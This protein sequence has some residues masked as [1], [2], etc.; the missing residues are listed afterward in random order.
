MH[1]PANKECSQEKHGHNLC[2]SGKNS[3][4]G[5]QRD[6]AKGTS[7]YP[8]E[9]LIPKAVANAN[10]PTFEALSDE[11]LLACCLHGGTQNQNEVI[12][13]LIW[14]HATKFT[15]TPVIQIIILVEII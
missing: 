6:L 10:L 7:E 4:C 14:Q 9:H 12:D 1:I 2:P 5:I 11:D 3:W 13:A 15:M 8:H